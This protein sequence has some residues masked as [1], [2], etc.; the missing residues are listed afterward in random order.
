[1]SNL[2]TASNQWASRPDDQRYLTLEDLHEAVLQRKVESNTTV[3][4]P[5]QM[6]V[7]PER[8]DLKVELIDP[9][10]GTDPVTA[11]LSNWSFG[12]LCSVAGNGGARPPAPYIRSLPAQLAAIN[13]QWG[14]EQGR[15]E[16]LAMY[17]AN[18]DTRLSAITST[19]YGRIWDSQVTKAVMDVNHN[20]NWKVPS[21]SYAGS[22]PKRA[23]TLYAS[24]RDVF[25][26]LVDPDHPIEVGNEMLFRGF[27]AWNSEVGK[28][29]FGLQTFLYRFVCDNRIVWGATEVKELR[30]RHTGGAPERFAHE[31]GRYL[32]RYANES[33]RELVQQISRAQEHKVA[34][35]PKDVTD[36]LRKHDFSK[37]VAESAVAKAEEEEGGATRLWSIIQGVTAHARGIEHTDTRI[38]LE[39]KAGALMK[40]VT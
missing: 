1:M 21:A 36:W 40:M 19:T 16:H 20:G 4:S 29:S 38:D 7:V 10:R 13:L 11:G 28:A 18:G 34:D 37:G 22:D 25:I 8:N 5:R 12:Q 35:T 33:S 39:R 6:K 9:A 3:I 27:F 14:L 17:R 26:F 30:I 32:Q 31:G 15:D 24:D 23:T 2:M